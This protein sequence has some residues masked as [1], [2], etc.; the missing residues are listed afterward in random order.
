MALTP[1]WITAIFTIIL[2]VA[3]I[4][5]VFFSFR[6]TQETVKLR[7]IETSPFVSAKNVKETEYKVK[8]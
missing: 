2:V 8:I 7:E 1:E 4:V 6:L 5:Y 3:T